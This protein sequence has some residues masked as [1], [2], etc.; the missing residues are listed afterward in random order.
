MGNFWHVLTSLIKIKFH[1]SDKSSPLS[2]IKPQTQSLPRGGEQSADIT[3]N[4]MPSALNYKNPLYVELE[5]SSL[6][7][8]AEYLYNTFVFTRYL[9]PATLFDAFVNDSTLIERLNTVGKNAYKIRSFTIPFIQ[10]AVNS[11]T[12]S[13]VRGLFHSLPLRSTLYTNLLSNNEIYTYS[14][15]VFKYDMRGNNPLNFDFC[16][17]IVDSN[18]LIPDAEDLTKIF[19]VFKDELE[20]FE[21]ISHNEDNSMYV[22]FSL[23]PT[24]LYYPEPY[25]ASPS[26]VHEEL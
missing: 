1:S 10:E 21:C 24:K 6:Q 13:L 3:T 8:K 22:R 26:F 16:S 15:P 14:L 17:S 4:N 5:L 12:N 18:K 19:P 20:L 11:H 7:F 23:P 9:N 2:E 25:V